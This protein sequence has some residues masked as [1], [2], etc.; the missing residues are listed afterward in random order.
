[1]LE[2]TDLKVSYGAVNAVQGVS[3]R[4]AVGE[5]TLLLGA[6][7]AGKTT[8][9]RA[10][11]GYHRP[12]SGSVVVNGVDLAGSRAHTMVRNRLVLVPEGRRVF[13]TLTVEE[14]LKIGG[15]RAPRGAVEKTI[16]EVYEQFPILYDRRRSQA[17][18]LSG[19]EQQM[20]AFGRAVMA[21]PTVIL[22][23]EPSMGLAPTMVDSV[24]TSVRAI[25]DRGIAVLIVE[26]NADAG[27]RIADRVSV[28]TRGKTV[29]AGAAADADK[30]AVHAVLG[31]A[32]LDET[33]SDP[34]RLEK[35]GLERTGLEGTGLERTGLDETGED[36]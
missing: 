28:I 18:L 36:R 29:W 25:A 34:V 13:A 19:G 12:K 35:T 15:Y 33:E 11:A 7:G 10:V 32:V 31:D 4:A 26:Q 30:A 16:A 17:G 9:L 23:D 20:L 24:M 21:Q 1:M 2:V 6:N 3:L 14:N 22:M 8:S 5:V 27:L